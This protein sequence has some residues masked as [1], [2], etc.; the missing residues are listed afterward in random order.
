MPRRYRRGVDDDLQRRALT[1]AD[2]PA[3]ARLLAA[4][5]QVDHTGEHFDDADIADFFAADGLDLAR[6]TLAV[7]RPDGELAAYAA[8]QPPRI[9]AGKDRVALSGIVRPDHRG[10]G[11]GRELLG[12]LETRGAEAHRAAQPDVPGEFEIHATEHVKAHTR[13]AERAGYSPVRYFITMRRD[14]SVPDT[15]VRPVPAPLRLVP[16]DRGYDDASRRA[17]NKAFADHYGSSQRSETEWKQ[18]FTGQRA[19]RPGCSFLILDG[20]E[21][22]AYLL[23]YFWEA[24]AEAT[25]VKE[26]YIGQVGCRAAW[27]GRGLA[28][29]LL[30]RAL[31]AFRAEGYARAALDVDTE[32]ATGALGLYQRLGFVTTERNVSY[33]K[34]VE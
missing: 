18:W 16:F 9:V 24:D 31:G 5:E 25:G 27:R 33:V 13:L 10:H 12:W 3:V 14:L 19:F 15:E 7:F 1:E 4:A 22:A 21:I 23:G 11:L 29:A 6:D 32:N 28:S 8:V 2:G 30:T 17:H 26:G 34:P 20:D